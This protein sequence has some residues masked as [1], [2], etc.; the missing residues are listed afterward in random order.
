MTSDVSSSSGKALVGTLLPKPLLDLDRREITASCI[1]PIQACW[2][3]VCSESVN[4]Q[5]LFMGFL[6]WKAYHRRSQSHNKYYHQALK[7]NRF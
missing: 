7:H 2:A 3:G 6:P 1:E 5:V 4:P